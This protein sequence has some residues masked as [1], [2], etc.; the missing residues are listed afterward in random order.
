MT[1]V[2][3]QLIRRRAGRMRRGTA[4]RICGDR[5]YAMVVRIKGKREE[6][7]WSCNWIDYFWSYYCSTEECAV[8]V[9]RVRETMQE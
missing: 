9:M 3:G 8:R 2:G 7:C 4:T 6:V 5:V 1:L